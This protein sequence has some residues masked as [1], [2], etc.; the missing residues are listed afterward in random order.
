[1]CAHVMLL[2]E[3]GGIALAHNRCRSGYIGQAVTPRRMGVM[4]RLIP[5]SFKPRNAL[6][7][8]PSEPRSGRKRI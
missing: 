6:Y 5:K 1:M 7:M 3:N 8:L 4:P 2:P